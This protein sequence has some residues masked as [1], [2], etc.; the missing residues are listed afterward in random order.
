VNGTTFT[1]IVLEYQ[2]TSILN[3]NYFSL[4]EDGQLPLTTYS[5]FRQE[6]EQAT[7]NRKV[8]GCSAYPI[9]ISQWVLPNNVTEGDTFEL[10]LND[11]SLND[12][13]EF[14]FLGWRTGHQGP[15]YLTNA[16]AGSLPFPGNSLDPTNGYEEPGDPS[17]NSLHRG[18]WVPYSTATV[19]DADGELQDHSTTDR[20]LRV[21]VYRY[22]APSAAEPNPKI[23]SQGGQV[24][25]LYRIDGFIVVRVNNHSVS[26]ESVTFEYVRED[27]SCGFA[28]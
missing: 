27:T 24:N 10:D 4:G 16:T 9:A 28:E 7:V 8:S 6:V 12:T 20:A 19:A 26:G 18:D 21:I 13:D 17:D 5:V 22:S 25:H 11:V 23:V 1:I 2:A 15:N 14:S 3:M